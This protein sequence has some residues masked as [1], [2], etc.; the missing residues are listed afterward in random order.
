V[1]DESDDVHTFPRISDG[2]RHLRDLQQEMLAFETEQAERLAE[3]SLNYERLL[4]EK[5]KRLREQR[6]WS[7]M[8]LAKRMTAHGV[9]M[10]QGTIAKTETARRPIRAAEVYAFAMVFGLP[11][12]ALWYVRFDDEPVSI[13]QMRDD[14]QRHDELIAETQQSL[15]S[16]FS[17]LVDQRARRHQTAEAINEAA[18]RRAAMERATGKGGEDGSTED[19]RGTGR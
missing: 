5:I 1:S 13:Q 4:G 19:Q 17:A 6:G 3:L 10:S 2:E 18:I 12:E 16:V 9:T 8:D 11:V 14:L 15:E 7:Q